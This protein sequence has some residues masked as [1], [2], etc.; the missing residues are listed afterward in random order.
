M[1]DFSHS[2]SS[3]ISSVLLPPATCL[4]SNGPL[5]SNTTL[6]GGPIVYPSGSVHTLGQNP[7]LVEVAH[8]PATAY[9][10]EET[11]LTADE[12]AVE[13]AVGGKSSKG[14]VVAGRKA[15]LVSALQTRDNARI[16][17]VGSGAMFSD[18][19]WGKKVKTADGQTWV[20]RLDRRTLAI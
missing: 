4:V 7:Y 19:Y 10:G 1:D 8:A 3:P 5:L 14:P 20:A 17:F 9:V 16:G 13:S 18:E 6:S 11:D 15:A 2:P 12:S